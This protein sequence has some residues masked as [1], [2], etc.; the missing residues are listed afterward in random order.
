VEF[1]T[2]NARVQKLAARPRFNAVLLST[3]ALMGVLLAGL[4]IYGV[5][6]FFVSQRTQEIGVRM[7]LGATSSRISRMV[8][9]SIAIWT[10][11]G[12]VLGMAGAWFAAKLMESLLF[13]VRA[14]DPVL[15]G[16]VFAILMVVALLSA[17]IP[18]RKAARV[19]PVVALRYE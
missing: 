13:E 1:L 4:G 5:V 3:F 15:L 12:A 7:A 17:W 14:H 16:M 8:L 2:M 19:D 11:S 18:A 10:A 9:K 6:S